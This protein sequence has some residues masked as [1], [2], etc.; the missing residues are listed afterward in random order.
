MNARAA[1]LAC[2]ARS[3]VL[4]LLVLAFV[5]GTGRAAAQDTYLLVITGVGGDEEHVAKFSKWSLAVLDAAKKQG[6]P[7]AQIT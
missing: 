4:S 3:S 7:D 5:A 1:R 2:R 6:L